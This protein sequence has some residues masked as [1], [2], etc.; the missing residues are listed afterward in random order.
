MEE[1]TL[2]LFIER[3]QSKDDAVRAAARDHAGPVGAKAVLPLAKIAVGG[4]LE[5]ARAAN[6]ALQNIVYHAGRPG[7]ENEA[8]AVAAE[9]LKLLGDSQPLQFR[10]DVLWMTWQI[11]GEEAVAPVAALL[12]NADLNEDARMALE[13]LPGEK[14]TA[15]LKA[16]LAKA[17]D[18]AKPALAHSLRVRGVE[19]P[20][21]PDLR[22]K[23]TK[24]TT[25]QPIGR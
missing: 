21:V 20:G 1:L 11:A 5:I 14:A 12:A 4:E 18:D 16:A 8:K 22:L 24:K 10:R 13:R 25:V 6:R 17:A 9:L 19:T 15:A 23:P 2:D 3:I 7:A